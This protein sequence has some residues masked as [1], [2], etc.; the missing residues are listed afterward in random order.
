MVGGHAAPPQELGDHAGGESVPLGLGTG[1]HD[2]VT[3]WSCWHRRA[4]GS[5]RH[6]GNGA[7]GV[8][9]GHGPRSERPSLTNLMLRRLENL[10]R[11]V[12]RPHAFVEQVEAELDRLVHLDVASDVEVPIPVLAHH[13]VGAHAWWLPRPTGV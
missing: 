12:F 5:Q 11:D 4:Q 9:L 10:E 6:V 8:L 2:R 7:G 1:D 3:L 13:V